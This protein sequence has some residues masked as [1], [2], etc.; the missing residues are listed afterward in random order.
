MDSI[1]QYIGFTNSSDYMIE[2]YLKEDSNKYIF[3]ISMSYPQY[4][5]HMDIEIDIDDIYDN[6]LSVNYID[7]HLIKNL[8][9]LI[10]GEKSSFTIDGNN[11]LNSEYCKIHHHNSEYFITQIDESADKWIIK[12]DN[13]FGDKLLNIIQEFYNDLLSKI[14]K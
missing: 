5:Y 9:K 3:T 12:F 4:R 11:S 8:K 1:W 2:G 13:N 10:A 14:K 6:S 7:K